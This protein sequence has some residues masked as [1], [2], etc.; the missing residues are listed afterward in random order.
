MEERTVPS[1]Q[2]HLLTHI[3]MNGV[4]HLGDTTS[5]GP[6]RTRRTGDGG[7]TRTCKQDDDDDVGYVLRFHERQFDTAPRTDP[8]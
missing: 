8:T 6:G 7:G 3:H 4:S 5:T 1:K 2:N